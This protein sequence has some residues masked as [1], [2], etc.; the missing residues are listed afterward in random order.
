MG[1]PA[2]HGEPIVDEVGGAMSNRNADGRRIN[3]RL[4]EGGKT[5]QWSDDPWKTASRGGQNIGGR[6]KNGEKKRGPKRC[7]NCGR[8]GKRKDNADMAMMDVTAGNNADGTLKENHSRPMPKI[9][10]PGNCIIVKA[11]VGGG[12]MGSTLCHENE[13]PFPEDLAEFFV[14]SFCP[15]GGTA[16]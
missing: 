8:D 3:E 16:L 7:T 11:R 5:R 13:A 15:P 9:A 6:E 4:T 1:G 14:L 2:R 10:N 12:H